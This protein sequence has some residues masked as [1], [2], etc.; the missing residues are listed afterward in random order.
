MMGQN[1]MFQIS[2]K[3][4]LYKAKFFVVL[5][6]LA[7]LA[8]N[9][10]TCKFFVVIHVLAGKQLHRLVLMQCSYHILGLSKNCNN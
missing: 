6:I 10:S 4:M 1:V 5:E 9:T 3:V 2:S 7:G 8:G